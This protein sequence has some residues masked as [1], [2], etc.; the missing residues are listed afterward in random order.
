[1][2][3]VGRAVRTCDG[4]EDCIVLDL[5]DRHH[6]INGPV[7]LGTVYPELPSILD[8]EKEDA[9]KNIKKWL[10]IVRGERMRE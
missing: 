6:D 8:S 2:Q 9:P 10:G 7:S 1:M 3:C 4:K 5:T